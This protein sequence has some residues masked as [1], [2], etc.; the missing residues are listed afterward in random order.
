[1]YNI[2]KKRFG[3]E[4]AQRH[5]GC[6]E[7]MA[8]REKLN[9]IVAAGDKGKSHP[10][11]GRNKAFLEVDGLPV[12]A[13]VVTALAESESVSEIYVAGPKGKLE[14]AL[15]CERGCPEVGKPVHI[16]EQRSTLY[17]N[18]WYTFLET[19]PEY[20]GGKSISEIAKGPAA[21]TVVLIVAAD[22][23]LLT[24]AEVDEFVSRC[25]MD[26]HDYVVG[27]TPEE[28]LEPFY[29]RG[30]KPGIKLAYMYFNEGVMRQNNMHMVRPFKIENR[31]Y[32]QTMY[33]LRYQ[34][35]F[36]NIVRLAWEILRREEGGWGALGYYLL[37][38]L[39]LLFARLRLYF[40]EKMIRKVTH[41]DSVARCIS[42]L[43]KTRFGYV[44]TSLGGAA[45]DIDRERD[46]E[47]MKSRFSEWRVY[48]EQKAGETPTR[49][50]PRR[51]PGAAD[52][53]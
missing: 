42:K 20:R 36:F 21:D 7:P 52:A 10:V 14:E 19:L 49:A 5:S 11:L 9:A 40:I 1:M 39:S 3:D 37:L 47:A 23:P 35:E 38:Q 6:D 28:S 18:V 15:S 8:Y 4:C 27:V 16:F 13:R 22:T 32:M 24:G 43:M 25:D 31:H 41:A 50:T 26:K 33:D 53:C 34:K 17:E 46:Y 29:P 48:L 12:V 30:G 2:T 45:L 51:F 44:F